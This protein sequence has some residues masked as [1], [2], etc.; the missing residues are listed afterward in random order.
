MALLA[1]SRNHDQAIYS[2]GTLCYLYQYA[3]R[4]LDVHG[5]SEREDVI[6]SK[7]LLT[8]LSGPDP[9]RDFDKIGSIYRYQ[10]GILTLRL[11]KGSVYGD[12]SA[13]VIIDV[14]RTFV[15]TLDRSRIRITIP[16]PL[17]VQ[18]LTDGRYL[19]C[20]HSELDIDGYDDH[21]AYK[22]LSWTLKLYDLSNPERLASIIALGEFMT[23]YRCVFKLL[24][25]WLYAICCDRDRFRDD[26][27]D[28]DRLYYHCCRFPVDDF[29]PAGPWKPGDLLTHSPYTPLPA[30]LEAVRIFR[31]VA[32]DVRRYRL[33]D[34]MQDECTSE[35]FTIESAMGGEPKVDR[36]YQRIIFPYPPAKT[37]SSLETRISEIVQTIEEHPCCSDEPVHRFPAYSIGD[38]GGRHYV[39]RSQSF[40]DFIHGLG[41]AV[42]LQQTFHL[43][44]GSRV[45]GS[46]IDPFTNLLYK[47]EAFTKPNYYLS[48]RSMRRFPPKGAPPDMLELLRVFPYNSTSGPS[49]VYADERSV[50]IVASEAGGLGTRHRL[51]LVNFDSGIHFPGFKPLTLDNLS[52]KISYEAL[53]REIKK[54][55]CD[56]KSDYQDLI[57]SDAY[58]SERLRQ[59][60]LD[61]NQRE[62][63]SEISATT[64]RAKPTELDSWFSKDEPAMHLKIGQGFQFHRYP[65]KSS[66]KTMAIRS[67]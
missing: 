30:R 49:I 22:A 5:A 35:V 19:V 27:D 36:S 10:N 28:A 62:D 46:P 58:P 1:H 52:D 53:V 56:D 21:L 6:D 43:C 57:Q 55:A 8:K 63:A 32:G 7:A 11:D 42:P 26:T 16:R 31:G 67:R 40:M 41:K 15:S 2:D 14:R 24:G 13:D 44:A 60:S 29:G 18:V 64:S 20:A 45:A 50:L 54:G 47:E 9:S 4:I 23:G 66:E 65:P 59:I 61:D 3:I 17:A 12:N 25:G 48:D 33:D 34:L 38:L 37:V 39:Q 51:I